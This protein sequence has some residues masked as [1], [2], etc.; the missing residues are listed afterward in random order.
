MRRWTLQQQ[1]SK[2]TYL[3]LIDNA[4]AAYLRCV[5]SGSKWGQNYWRTV[6]SELL[7]KAELT[8]H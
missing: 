3:R 7:R 2:T 4:E 8:V 1:Y 6:I 5:A